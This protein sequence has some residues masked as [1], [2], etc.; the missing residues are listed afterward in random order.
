MWGVRRGFSP[1]DASRAIGGGTAPPRAGTLAPEHP[2]WTQFARALAP[3][4]A[5]DG[6]LIAE[7][8]EYSPSSP[9][10]VVD[11]ACGHGHYGISVAKR[12]PLA[13]IFAQD[14]PDVLE[15]AVANARASSP[16]RNEPLAGRHRD[17]AT[18]RRGGGFGHGCGGRKSRRIRPWLLGPRCSNSRDLGLPRRI[19]GRGAGLPERL[20]DG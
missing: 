9:M 15:V 13:E 18:Y 20:A 16:T 14:W 10:R 6:K 17:G 11:I 8:L 5:A 3:I 1:S 2:Y 4:G 19:A 7:I 12:N